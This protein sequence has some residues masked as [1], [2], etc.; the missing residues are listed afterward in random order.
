MQVARRALR[1]PM[2]EKL[3]K[4]PA[5]DS[6]EAIARRMQAN[7]GCRAIAAVLK[8]MTRQPGKTG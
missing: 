4:T 8:G 2:A 7:R 1:A 3:P 6:L 5:G